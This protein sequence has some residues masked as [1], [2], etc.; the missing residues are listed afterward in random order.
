M[1]LIRSLSS[2]LARLMW[3][4]AVLCLLGF[5]ALSVI[6]S[7]IGSREAAGRSVAFLAGRPGAVAWLADTIIDQVDSEYNA[8]VTPSDRQ[9]VTQKITELLNGPQLREIAKSYGAAEW[10]VTFGTSQVAQVDVSTITAPL[11]EQ[12]RTI[13]PSLADDLARYRSMEITRPA[14]KAPSTVLG[15]M[16]SWRG[17][18]LV[19]LLT[20]FVLSLL[21]DHHH[22][23]TRLR[24]TS[25][26]VVIVS[27]AAT[28]I[29]FFASKVH[30]A[31]DNPAT[32]IPALAARALPW[33]AAGLILGTLGY[34]GGALLQ[35][36]RRGSAA[37]D[38]AS[39]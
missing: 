36:R 11:S 38:S 33:A 3:T 32:I 9:F 8:V 30:F 12:V 21:L 18:L 10:D 16:R 35:S 23:G 7:V 13:S 6:L 1:T 19:G 37:A 31:P 27:V 25:R 14:G 24:R 26:R 34:L 17:A 22:V 5:V 2:L 15:T 39:A 29:S 4:F 28:V 20:G